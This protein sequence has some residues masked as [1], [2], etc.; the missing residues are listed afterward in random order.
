[1]CF[2]FFEMLFLTGRISGM[3]VA[4]GYESP[5]VDFLTGDLEI[6]QLPY[7]PQGI[8]GSSMVSHFGTIL[9]C[10]GF[11]NEKNCLKFDNGTWK[12]HSTFDK[13]RVWHSAVTT[14]SATFVFGGVDS[15]EIYEYLPKDSTKWLIGKTEIPGGFRG[16]CA[17]AVKSEQEIWLIGGWENERR[18]LTF[19]INDHTFQMLTF[20]LSVERRGHRCAFIPNTNKVMI[21]GGYDYGS[22]DSTEVLD[23][24]FSSVQIALFGP[25]RRKDDR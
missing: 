15:Y 16:G 23:I 18:I 5:V 7:L 2:E 20:Q 19:N 22:L 25:F 3:I 21:T 1:M 13:E 10:G 14:Q 4:G 17:V 9:L 6:K 24:F 8:D 11:G 12:K